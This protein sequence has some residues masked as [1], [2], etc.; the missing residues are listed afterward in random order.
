MFILFHLTWERVFL[1]FPWQVVAKKDK[2]VTREMVDGWRRF[3]S[4]AFRLHEIDGHHLF[5]I[6]VP[7]AKKVWLQTIVDA[8]ESIEK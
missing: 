5:P 6:S 8:I 3:T 7:P 1:E 4:A 2:K